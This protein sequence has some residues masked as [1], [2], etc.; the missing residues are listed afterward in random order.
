MTKK[1]SGPPSPIGGPDGIRIDKESLDFGTT[2]SVY[3]KN[4]FLTYLANGG[5]DCFKLG[6]CFLLG[7]VRP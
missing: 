7:L 1:S 6:L 5:L 3:V 2:Q 4:C